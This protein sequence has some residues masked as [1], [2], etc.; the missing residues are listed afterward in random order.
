[1]K[2][3]NKLY[4]TGESFINTPSKHLLTSICGGGTQKPGPLSRI[5]KFCRSMLAKIGGWLT[6]P[7]I[8]L[9]GWKRIEFRS[10]YQ[11]PREPRRI[12]FPRWH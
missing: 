11:E 8:D 2:A 3:Q 10:E 6:R 12:D 5:W 7:D 1:M 4:E 9:E